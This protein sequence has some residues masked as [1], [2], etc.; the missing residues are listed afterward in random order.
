MEK[1]LSEEFIFVILCLIKELSS[2]LDLN[3]EDSEFFALTPS[4]ECL[5][6]AGLLMEQHGYALPEV[7]HHVL[8]RHA[9][10]CN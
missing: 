7:Y 8:V 5:K 9:R 3:Y 2:E 6:N 10:N 1:Q 4:V